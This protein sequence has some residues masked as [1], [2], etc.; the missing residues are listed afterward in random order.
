MVT[1]PYP[2]HPIIRAHSL[3]RNWRLLIPFS[4]M[5]GRLR[6][7]ARRGAP[8]APLPMTAGLSFLAVGEP[9]LGGRGR[10]SNF[11]WATIGWGHRRALPGTLTG[12]PYPA[13]PRPTI[14]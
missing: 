1:V 2:H 10:G 9:R 14:C 11:L 7:L 4:L 13:Y 5:L 8:V 3:G 6:P 12:W